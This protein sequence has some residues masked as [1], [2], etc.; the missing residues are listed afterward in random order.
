MVDILLE[1]VLHNFRIQVQLQPHDP[2]DHHEVQKHQDPAFAVPWLTTFFVVE[3]QHILTLEG[4]FLAAAVIVV[5][6]AVIPA[7][8]VR[9]LLVE[10]PVRSR[11]V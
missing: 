9:L 7:D 1:L 10:T 2:P 6:V 11:R 8:E 3:D 4:D 5:G